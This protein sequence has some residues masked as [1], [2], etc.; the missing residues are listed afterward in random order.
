MKKRTFFVMLILFLVLL[1]SMI[2]VVSTVIL[3]DKLSAAK[4]KCLAEHYV[5]AS[6][7]IGDIQALEQRGNNVEENI[8]KLM[9][10]YSRY[11]QGNG[12]GLAVAFSGE[13][14][15]ESSEFMQAGNMIVPPDTDCRQER[16]VYMDN[17]TYPILCVYGSFPPPWQDYGLMYV[18]NLSNT[19]SSIKADFQCIYEDCQRRL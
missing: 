9:S 18:G 19:L 13:W 1:N 17:E 3:N 16:I 10:S 7:L 8:D 6:S 4:D 11:L 12:G 5:I 2:L 15:Y 14:I